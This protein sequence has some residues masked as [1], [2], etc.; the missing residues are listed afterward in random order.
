MKKL[1]LYI[2]LI[3]GSIAF[4]YPFYWMVTAS[5]VPENEIESLT[6]LPHSISFNSYIQM[7]EKIPIGR[8]FFNSIFVATMVTGGVLVFCS[9]VG[10]AL[11]RLRFVGRNLIFYI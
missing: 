7:F 4:I 6:L 5:L 10:Y 11:S 8:A 2:T 9:M 3:I 1:I